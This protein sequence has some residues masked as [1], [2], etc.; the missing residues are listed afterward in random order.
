MFFQSHRLPGHYCFNFW[1][2]MLLIVCWILFLSRPEGDGWCQVTD[3]NQISCDMI[4][5][6]IQ[7]Q[8]CTMDWT[9]TFK[10][11]CYLTLTHC[12]RLSHAVFSLLVFIL[13]LILCCLSF[14]TSSFVIMFLAFFISDHTTHMC[15]NASR[16]TFCY[17]ALKQRAQKFS[18]L[19][20][21]RRKLRPGFLSTISD[22]LSPL[23]TTT[24]KQGFVSVHS[25]FQNII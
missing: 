11:S 20:Y 15:T 14:L 1:T 12:D 5:K 13:S 9:H 2:S 25:M 3:A 6:L 19:L 16:S 10:S 8:C 17:W 4:P 23:E 22:W 18:E 21:H 24:Q 7:S